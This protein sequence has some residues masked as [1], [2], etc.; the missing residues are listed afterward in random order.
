VE[1]K[2][3]I[4]IDTAKYISDLVDCWRIIYGVKI[5]AEELEDL[6]RLGYCEGGLAALRE[7]EEAI[8]K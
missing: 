1:L 6:Y 5:E 8:A 2:I 7:A 4:P 3:P